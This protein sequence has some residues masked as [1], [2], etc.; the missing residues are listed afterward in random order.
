M[1]NTIFNNKNLIFIGFLFLGIAGTM[2]SAFFALAPITY[3]ACLASAYII[4][5]RINDHAVNA[6]YN[7][8]VKWSLFIVFLYLTGR[9]L[10]E[11][12]VYAMFSYILINTT[13]SPMFFI[14][15][16]RAST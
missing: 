2:Q 4:S 8:S 14:S 3:L 15:K 9:Y 5:S 7:W 1:F 12:F 13:V 10:N 16:T 6:V 11:A